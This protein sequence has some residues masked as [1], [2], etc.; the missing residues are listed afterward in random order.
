MRRTC[1]SSQHSTTCIS[2]NRRSSRIRE[3][4]YFSSSCFL[5]YEFLFCCAR[6]CV[7]STC[8]GVK[9]SSKNERLASHGS[10][11]KLSLRSLAREGSYFLRP[12]GY[13]RSIVPSKSFNQFEVQP[14]YGFSQIQNLRH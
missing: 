2:R 8:Q 6:W 7:A 1:S 4:S 12:G 14:V 3:E 10:F 13:D 9:V 11:M 5:R